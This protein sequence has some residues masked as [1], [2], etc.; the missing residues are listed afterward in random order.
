MWQNFNNSWDTLILLFSWSNLVIQR[1]GF[2]FET[3]YHLLCLNFKR[4]GL[5]F[6]C[7]QHYWGN[8]SCIS[9]WYL[10][11]WVLNTVCYY[12]TKATKWAALLILL[13]SPTALAGIA[14]SQRKVRQ[15]SDPVQQILIQ[16]HKIIFITQVCITVASD[17]LYFLVICC[18]QN[19]V[20]AKCC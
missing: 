3:H 16:L 17:I 11:L 4:F 7:S 5:S 15:I 19:D 9:T 10:H 18:C 12:C 14:V 2:S 20:T 1:N 13:L 6:F 8:K